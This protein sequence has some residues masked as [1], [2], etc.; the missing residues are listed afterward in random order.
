MKSL[1]DFEIHT[2]QG[3]LLDWQSFKN[4]K[5]LIFNTASECGYTHQ[6]AGLEQLYRDYKDHDFEII[7]LPCNDFGAQ[8]PGSEQEILQF[9]QKSFEVSFMLTEKVQILG[10]NAH[11]IYKWL[12]EKEQNGVG[13]FPVAWNFQKFGIDENGNLVKSFPTAMDP[14]HSD[15]VNWITQPQLF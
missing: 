4:K 3:T 6:L 12:Q 9:C 7:G 11:P 1:F 8:E 5:I 2:I 14:Q 10:P 15:I 13:D